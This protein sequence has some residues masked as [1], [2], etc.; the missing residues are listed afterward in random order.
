MNALELPAADAPAAEWGRLAMRI[1]GWCEPPEGLPSAWLASSHDWV[2]DPDH[3]SWEGWLLKLLGGNT[4]VQVKY[5]P[6]RKSWEVC[7][8]APDSGAPRWGDGSTLGRACIAA[9]A[10]LG[11]WPGGGAKV[12]KP[13]S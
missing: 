10:A 5:W 6:R 12:K 4:Q 9:A 2:P 1:P 3:W 11:R 8:N 13:Q 7:A